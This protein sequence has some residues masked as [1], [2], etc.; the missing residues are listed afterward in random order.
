VVLG[1]IALTVTHSSESGFQQSNGGMFDH[2][3]EIYGQLPHLLTTVVMPFGSNHWYLSLLLALVPVTGAVIY[4]LLPEGAELR[5]ELR[6]WGLVMA[7]GAIVI[8]ASYVIFVP[9]LSYYVP[10]RVGIAD[11]INAV[12]SI[13]WVLLFYGGARMIG[14]VV[15]RGLP[16][17]RRLG[18]GL[19][20]VGCALVAIGWVNSVHAESDSYTG[21][22]NEDLR[23]LASILNSIPK[24]VA[25]STIWTFGQPVL[26]A[27]E[28][29]V[30]GNTWD[31]TSSVQLQYDDPSLASYVA[32]PGTVF[33]CGAEKVTPTVAYLEP[34]SAILASTYGRTYFINTVTGEVAKIENQADCRRAVSSFAPSPFIRE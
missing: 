12:P 21:A 18:Q 15:F 17:G 19:A 28:I 23:V 24:P 26:Y 1:T 2:A 13:G 34:E 6:R 33:E 4:R 16:E 9:A 31:M 11:R 20:V 5:G 3:R 29:P 10:L 14:A 25:E 32:L 27:P 7:A 22:F 30:F 8:L